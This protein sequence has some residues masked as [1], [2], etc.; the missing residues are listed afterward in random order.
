MTEIISKIKELYEAIVKRDA[1]SVAKSIHLASELTKVENKAS[2]QKSLDIEL[3]NKQTEISKKEGLISANDT[4]ESLKTEA[5]K[6]RENM[7]AER[8]T[9]SEWVVKE[10]I[11]V[12]KERKD[13]DASLLEVER[14]ENATEAKSKKLDEDRKTYKEAIIKEMDKAR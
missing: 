8:K 1:D 10:K 6:L 7:V 11:E 12:A 2:E 13:I 4:V 5:V 3:S 14:R 9:C